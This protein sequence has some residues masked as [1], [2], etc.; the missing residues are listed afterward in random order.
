[1]T[2]SFQCTGC[3]RTLKVADD[4]AGRKGKCPQCKAMLYIPEGEKSAVTAAPARKKAPPPTP[5]PEEEETRDEAAEEA[6]EPRGKKKK[7]AKEAKKSMLL[8]LLLVGGGV[9]FLLCAGG[10]TALG[11]WWFLS[12]GSQDDAYFYPDN[13]QAVVSIKL[14]QLLNSAA[15]QQAR[16]EFPDLN[17]QLSQVSGQSGGVDPANID[18]I[19]AASQPFG[20]GMA[21]ANVIAIV[22]TKQPVKP[23]DVEASFQKS[24]PNLKFNE[25]KVGRFTMYEG[26]ASAPAPG[27][28]GPP[29][30]PPAFVMPDDKRIVAGPASLVRSVLERDKKPDLPDKLQALLKQT[31]LDAT[32][33]FVADAKNAFPKGVGQVGAGQPGAAKN[34]FEKV[35]GLSVTAKVTSD[36]DVTVTA[37]CADAQAANDLRDNVKKTLDGYKGLLTLAQLG[38]TKIPPEVNDLLDINPQVNG[39]TVTVTKKIQVGPLLKLAKEQQEKQQKQPPGF[40]PP[41]GK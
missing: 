18:R 9:L 14:D 26:Q 36:V 1:M 40:V 25:V 3:G 38:G 35:D 32:V 11:L 20:G 17:Q 5:P 30:P 10:G 21:Q 31:D 28:F 13:T 37:T 8:P 15:M 6:P 39:S 33:V 29:P 12:G 19:V 27:M 23:A 16:Q 41:G 24:Q 4:L 7:K 22:H 2:I 34:P